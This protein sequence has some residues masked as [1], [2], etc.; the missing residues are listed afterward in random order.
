MEIAIIAGVV[1]L[2]FG[3]TK[4]PKLGGAIGESIKNFKKGVK[5][6]TPQLTDK[7]KE[8]DKKS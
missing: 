7:N 6:D 2:L 8:D 4:L 5:D 3:T 1:V